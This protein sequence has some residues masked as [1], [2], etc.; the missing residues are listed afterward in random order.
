MLLRS[1]EYL[2]TD[3]F[4]D[5]GRVENYKCVCV[6]VCWR[7]STLAVHNHRIAK[8][9]RH[10]NGSYEVLFQTGWHDANIFKLGAPG[11]EKAI[12]DIAQA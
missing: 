4:D 7:S 6:C 11:M 9:V 5:L 10:D 8:I 1:A 12:H 3:L 2:Q